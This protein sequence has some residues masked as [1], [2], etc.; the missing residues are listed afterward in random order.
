MVQGITIILRQKG[1]P[2][3]AIPFR[4]YISDFIYSGDA[5]YEIFFGN[6]NAVLVT[7]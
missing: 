5:F 4:L 3:L 1:M 6:Y 7:I 2:E